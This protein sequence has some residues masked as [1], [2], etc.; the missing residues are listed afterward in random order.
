MP[1]W[2]GEGTARQKIGIYRE[3]AGTWFLDGNGNGVFNGCGSN[4]CI[5]WGSAPVVQ[6]HLA[7]DGK[8]AKPHWVNGRR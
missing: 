6:Y 1:N 5:A 4:Q 3:V 2:G 8:L 7:R